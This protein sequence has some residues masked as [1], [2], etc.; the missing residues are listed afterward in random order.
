[1]K[2]N[3]V[4]ARRRIAAMIR[5][6][7]APCQQNGEILHHRYRASYEWFITKSSSYR[8]RYDPL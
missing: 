7:F 3:S 1:M 2:G 4:R 5:V 8:R 6:R